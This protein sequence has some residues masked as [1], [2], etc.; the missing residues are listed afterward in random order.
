[1][2]HSYQLLCVGISI[3]VMYILKLFDDIN[4]LKNIIKKH[5]NRSISLIRI[6]RYNRDRNESSNDT[7]S[8]PCD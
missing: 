7:D 5:T 6:I 3:L 8:D 1:M 4:K 2:I